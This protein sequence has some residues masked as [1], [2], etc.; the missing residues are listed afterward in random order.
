MLQHC[1]E[2][3][4]AFLLFLQSLILHF[5]CLPVVSNILIV[6]FL[7]VYNFFDRLNYVDATEHASRVSVRK[8]LL[9]GE[10]R[11]FHFPSLFEVE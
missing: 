5:L 8:V 7:L 1:D 11:V 10:V 9:L 3:V 2:I 6:E 4:L